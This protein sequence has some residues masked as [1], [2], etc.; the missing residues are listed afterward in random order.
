MVFFSQIEDNYLK[1]RN[2]TTLS[3]PGTYLYDKKFC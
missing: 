2:P 3:G 1:I